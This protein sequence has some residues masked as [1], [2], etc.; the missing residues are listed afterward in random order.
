M[1]TYGGSGCID[2]R[3]LDF[4][5]TWGGEGR[6]HTPATLPPVT[7]GQKAGWVPEQCGEETN[8]A[9]N[10]TR[11]PTPSAVQLVAIPTEL[12]RLTDTSLT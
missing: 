10:R 7:T 9:P 6:V 3:I 5:T 8:L 2:P 1:K 4:S 11:I 12:S